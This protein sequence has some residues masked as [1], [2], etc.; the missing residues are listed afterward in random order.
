MWS[1]NDSNM[2]VLWCATGTIGGQ[3][4]QIVALAVAHATPRNHMWKEQR[5]EE[6]NMQVLRSVVL[7][8]AML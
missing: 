3:V 8:F 5:W 6:A 2:M 7:N 4:N 1:V